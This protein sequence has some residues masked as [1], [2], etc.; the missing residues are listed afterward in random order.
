MRPLPGPKTAHGGRLRPA[1]FRRVEAVDSPS[2]ACRE[3]VSQSPSPSR[4][5]GRPRFALPSD[6]RGLLAPSRRCAAREAAAGGRRGGRASRPPDT[7][8]A[9]FAA[10]FGI[11]QGVRAGAAGRGQD[12]GAGGTDLAGTGED[13]P[14]RIRGRRQTGYHRP[15]V[16]CVPRTGHADCRQAESELTGTATVRSPCVIVGNTERDETPAGQAGPAARSGRV[17]PR[18]GLVGPPHQQTFDGDAFVEFIPVQTIARMA[19]P[20]VLP[21]HGARA[22]Q[23]R[24]PRQGHPERTAVVQ[25]RPVVA[26]EGELPGPN[27]SAHSRPSRSSPGARPPLRPARKAVCGCSPRSGQVSPRD[28][29]RIWPRR[30]RFPL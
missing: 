16:P 18:A 11:G 24:E 3:P 2:S 7:R 5:T 4:G 17:R 15:A 21:L 29:T 30:H 12:E 28:T 19:D 13:H 1:T 10:A 9:F 27:R 26:V 14:G 20:V 25:P 23:S 6:L 22:H 8:R